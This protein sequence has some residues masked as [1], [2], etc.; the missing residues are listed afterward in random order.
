MKKIIGCFNLNS[1]SVEVFS[2]MLEQHINKLQDDGQEV[3][4]QY[5]ATT[6]PDGMVSYNALI[7]GRK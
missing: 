3:E 1:T 5:Q 6:L 4:V 2:M 7:L